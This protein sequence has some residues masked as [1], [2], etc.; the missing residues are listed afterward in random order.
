MKIATCIVSPRED[1]WLVSN[2][3]QNK[4]RLALLEATLSKAADM[5]IAMV[6][7][8]ARYFFTEMA[9]SFDR[10]CDRIIEISTKYDVAIAVGIDL[11]RKDILSM[12]QSD[13]EWM[14]KQVKCGTGFPWYAVVCN[15]RE[16]FSDI[17]HLRS[18]NWKHSRTGPAHVCK[19]PRTVP[20][21]G[22]GIEI[23]LCGE[24]FNARIR[25]SV[26]KRRSDLLAAVDLVHDLDGYM[27]S[28]TMK[29]FSILQQVRIFIAGHAKA[30][31][32]GC[33]AFYPRGKK[34][35]PVGNR[36]LCLRPKAREPYLTM[37][38]WNV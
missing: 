13:K 14:L 31:S 22:S 11:M 1:D 37:R 25:D 19:K 3:A 30:R 18:V 16:G 33:Y 10:L 17:W 5:G 23:L 24:V 8:P 6:F 4:Y 2:S 20:I 34:K 15:P 21:E 35:V 36:F 38:I 28:D 32:A 26:G 27:I 12:G 7:F 9:W 29:E